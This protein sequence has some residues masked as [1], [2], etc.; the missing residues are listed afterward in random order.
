MAT[1]VILH[2]GTTG[3]WYMGKVAR[4][5]R[6]AGHEV[7][8][9]TYTGLGERAHLLNREIDLDTHIQDILNVFHYEDLDDVILVGKSYS[10]LVIT[11]VAEAIPDQIRHLVYLDAL[12]PQD[13]QSL[14][15]MV[16]PEV[17][18]QIDELV[19][20]NGDGWLL[21]A[22]KSV[23]SRLTDHPIKTV[24]G[25]VEIKNPTAAAL[26][27]TYICCTEKTE[28]PF[29]PTL[30]RVAQQAKDAGW[31]YRELPTHHEP[32]ISMPDEVT[33]LLLEFV[34]R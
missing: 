7:F 20:A 26:P 16:G 28:S 27:R 15:D 4:R 18:A 6:Q 13:G 24:Y 1:Y 5:L 17:M 11:A 25:K 19:Q 31:S 30:Y 29:T 34:D 3:G 9:P 14:A 21:P 12:V 22:A 8:T 10:G 33:E 32:E 2:G 23:D